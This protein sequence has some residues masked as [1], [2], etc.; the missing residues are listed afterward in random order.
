MS[1][2]LHA[3]GTFTLL[4]VLSGVLLSS[5]FP[6]G[7]GRVARSLGFASRGSALLQGSPFA[8]YQ[9]LFFHSPWAARA[10]A[11]VVGIVLLYGFGVLFGRALRRRQ[12]SKSA[13]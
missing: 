3:L 4:L 9:S 8:G 6:D 10:S 5:A 13:P 1:R 7:L 2:L 12:G 11:G